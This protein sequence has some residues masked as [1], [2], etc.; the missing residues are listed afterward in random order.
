MFTWAKKSYL[1][2]IVNL[3]NL[4]LYILQELKNGGVE[5]DESVVGGGLGE[6]WSG[7]NGQRERGRH[8]R[9]YHLPV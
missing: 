4:I 9:Q 7:E 1:W 6:E 8:D 2:E 3:G 5:N